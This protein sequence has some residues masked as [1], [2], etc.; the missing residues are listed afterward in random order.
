M[1]KIVIMSDNHG[2][3]DA[4]TRVYE[5]EPDGDYY[6]HCGDSEARRKEELAGYIC[7]MGNNDWGLK[8]PKESKLSIEGVDIL[9][10]HG[11]FFG[12]F[13]K[14]D[15]MIALLKK[16]DCTVL[17]SGHTHMPSIQEVDGYLLVNP[18][19]TNLP[20]GGSDPSYAIMTI[21]Q[22]EINV[23]IKDFYYDDYEG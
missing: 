17:L 14:E 11:Q 2:I 7:V 23:E 3:S 5:L 16:N 12:Y 19:S 1:K 20:R 10:T 9:I 22:G 8:L 18:G 6:I 4:M 21:D 15:K 13:N